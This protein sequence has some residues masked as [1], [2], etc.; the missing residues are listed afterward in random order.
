MAKYDIAVQ[1]T[2]SDGNAFAIIG[3]VAGAL[4]KAG[5]DKTQ[6]DSFTNEAMNDDY[7]HVLA[8]CMECVPVGA[9][10][11]LVNFGGVAQTDDD[12]A[13]AQ[14]VAGR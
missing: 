13:R 4:R 3:K 6:I 1:L 11:L 2:G 12:R 14:E 7:I 8:T 9:L 5:V 10:Y